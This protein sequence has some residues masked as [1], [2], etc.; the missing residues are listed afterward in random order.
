MHIPVSAG[1]RVLI[2]L[3]VAVGSATVHVRGW[4][5]AESYRRHG[6]DVAFVD[7]RDASEEEIATRARDFDLVYLIKVR[8][9]SLVQRLRS[10]GSKVVFDLT[11]PLWENHY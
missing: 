1:R 2:V 11:D 7:V 3:D 4:R 10:Q 6:W 8:S 5:F 9:F